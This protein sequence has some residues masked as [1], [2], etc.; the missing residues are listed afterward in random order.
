MNDVPGEITQLLRQMSAGRGEVADKLVPLVYRELHRVAA[1]QM[2]RE[3]PGHTLQPTAL[4]HEAYLRLVNKRDLA[5][6]DRMHFFAVAAREMR[7]VLVDLARLRHAKKRGGMDARQVDLDEVN[8]YSEENLGDLLVLND[9]LDRLAAIDPRQREI[10]ELRFFAG[11]TVEEVAA[12]LKI[13]TRTVTREWNFAK[14]WLHA[15][16]AGDADDGSGA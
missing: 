13:S 8:I 16:L 12:S 4:V 5:W 3:K 1:R 11:L 15:E 6:Q 2:A 7:R 14:A 9:A 10:V